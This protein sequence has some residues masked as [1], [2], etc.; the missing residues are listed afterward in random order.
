VI[1][2]VAARLSRERVD[3]DTTDGL[4]VSTSRGWWLL[5]ASGSESKLTARCESVDPEGLQYLKRQLREQLLLSGF[6][7]PANQLPGSA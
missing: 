7:L 6:E 2:E 1:Q 5:R 3:L 4:R